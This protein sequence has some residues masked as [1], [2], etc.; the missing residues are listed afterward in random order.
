MY[1]KSQ[2]KELLRRL[3]EA[4]SKN[5]A[6]MTAPLQTP[7]KSLAFDRGEINRYYH[8]D[9]QL[10]ATQGGFR[11]HINSMKNSSEDRPTMSRTPKSD[12]FDIEE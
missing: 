8:T 4:N 5:L 1:L 9:R 3:N 6:F 2:N 12:F 7:S 10:L 11:A